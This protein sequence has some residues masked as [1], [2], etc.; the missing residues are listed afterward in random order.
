MADNQYDNLHDSGDIKELMG[1][2]KM[3]ADF[4]PLE[5][6]SINNDQITEI[7]TMLKKAYETIFAQEEKIRQLESKNSLPSKEEVESMSAMLDVLN[8]MDIA[9]LN[10]LTEFGNKGNTK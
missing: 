10:K 7:K 4:L 1:S 9:T 3:T 8:K 6:K 5:S 2:L